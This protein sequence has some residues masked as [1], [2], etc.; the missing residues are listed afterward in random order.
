MGFWHRLKFLSKPRSTGSGGL[1]D[2]TNTPGS[3]GFSARDNALLPHY[4]PNVNVRGP[5][6]EPYLHTGEWKD[7]F[8]LHAPPDTL[9]PEIPVK[10]PRGTPVTGLVYNDP[11]QPGS[12]G[13]PTVQPAQAAPVIGVAPPQTRQRDLA[14]DA[15]SFRNLQRFVFSSTPSQ[16]Y[17]NQRVPIQ[18]YTTPSV[19]AHAVQTTIYPVQ[20]GWE[21]AFV[22]EPGM[23]FPHVGTAPPTLLSRPLNV[24]TN[25]GSVEGKRSPIKNAKAPKRQRSGG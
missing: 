16:V 9:L 22:P 2:N 18:E 5:N 25:V 3:V 20:T 7:P 21:Q 13:Q 4:S 17:F 23:H 11:V 1:W 15:G 24:R 8:R 12:P 14:F 19:P 10:E 6:P